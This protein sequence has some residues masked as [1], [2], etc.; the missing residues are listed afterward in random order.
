MKNNE[1]NGPGLF[2][3]LFL[4]SICFFILSDLYFVHILTVFF[5]FF[6][7]SFSFPFPFPFH[8]FFLFFFSFF[9]F[10]PFPFPFPFSFPFPFPFSFSCLSFFFSQEKPNKFQ[11]TEMKDY[12]A[13]KPTNQYKET[14]DLVLLDIITKVYPFSFLFSFT[15]LRTIFFVFFL[16]F[17]NIF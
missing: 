16:F 6:S 2:L 5:S 14:K 1:H 8:F 4:L 13:Q 7:F 15:Y 10:F 9:F 12:R 17:Y 11:S 3:S